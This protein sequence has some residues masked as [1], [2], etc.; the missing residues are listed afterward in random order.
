MVKLWKNCNKIIVKL[1]IMGKLCYFY[2]IRLDN[3]YN[4]TRFMTDTKS[5]FYGQIMIKL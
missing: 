4:N 5:Q 1:K 2:S 3:F